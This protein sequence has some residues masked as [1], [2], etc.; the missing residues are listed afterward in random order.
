MVLTTSYL[1]DRLPYSVLDS[2]TPMEVLSSFFPDLFTSSN[3]TPIIFGCTSFVYIRSDGIGKLDPKA[4]ICVFIGY[5]STQKG[6]KR[7]HPPSHKF[8]VSQDVTFHEQESYFVQNHLHGENSC[9]EEES[10]L[11]PDLNIG[12]EIGVETGG[13]N[14]KTKVIPEST[15]I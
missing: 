14:V 5:S 13:D 3:L 6:Y 4:L 2:K 15:H 7:Y 10:L 9:K 1:I 12:P 8:F 11:L